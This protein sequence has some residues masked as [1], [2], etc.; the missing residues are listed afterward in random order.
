MYRRIALKRLKTATN[1][2]C[3]YPTAECYNKRHNS[4]R[5][6]A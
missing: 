6:D 4:L 5:N 3:V 2:N 1:Y